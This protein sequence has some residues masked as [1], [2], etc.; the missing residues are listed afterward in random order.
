MRRVLLTTAEVAELLRKPESTIRYYRHAGIGPRSVRIGRTV[1]YDADE[2][3]VWI[4][5]HFEESS[6]GGS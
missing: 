3:D 6:R 5:S 1:Y 2:L 4:E